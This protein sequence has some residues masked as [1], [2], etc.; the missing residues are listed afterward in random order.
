MKHHDDPL[1]FFP[2][3]GWLS[4]EQR[5]TYG[6]D[7][8]LALMLLC[9]HEPGRFRI[10]LKS[11]KDL[12]ERRVFLSRKTKP[13]EDE[14]REALCR[15]LLNTHVPP[16]RRILKALMEVFVPRDDSSDSA[17]ASYPLRARLK[18]RSTNGPDLRRDL[19]I[20]LEVDFL[21]QNGKTLEEAAAEVG[22]TIGR[23]EDHIKRIY[24]RVKR[25]GE[26]LG[27]APQ[28]RKR[29]RPRSGKPVKPVMSWPTPTE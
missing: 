29:G 6:R 12:P 16:S 27:S 5:E 8:A 7:E 14:A 15:I 23:H 25:S 24:S 11:E 13:T 3:G 18:R 28:S 26:L 17:Y 4:E 2:Y 9:G 22:E 19:A 20:S 21:R 1:R 10:G